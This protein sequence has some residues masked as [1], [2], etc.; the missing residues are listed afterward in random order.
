[1]NLTLKMRKIVFLAI[2][3]LQLLG[4]EHIAAQSFIHKPPL[5]IVNGERWSE[6]Q[7]K[8]I[9]PDDIVSEELL[10]A[11]E[12]SVARYGQEASNGVIIISLRY[13]TE[14]RFEPEGRAVNP[15]D[16]LA[17][18]IKWEWPAN[19]VARVVVRLRISAE[20]V[21]TIAEVIDSTDK[22]FLKRVQK[23]LSLMPRWTPARKA[24]KGVEYDYILRLTLPEGMQPAQRQSVPIIVG[25]A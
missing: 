3:L 14:A 6:Q 11:D 10:P 21:A 22:R 25:G 19:P 23:A 17:G 12:N 4:A 9:D 5:Y 7:V 2:L 15:A 1:M 18:Q 8:A 16:Y 24:G 13:D 20:G